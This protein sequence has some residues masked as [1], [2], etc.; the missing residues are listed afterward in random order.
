[1][2]KINCSSFSCNT[3]VTAYFIYSDDWCGKYEP[4]KGYVVS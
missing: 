2:K 1:M 4:S 3:R